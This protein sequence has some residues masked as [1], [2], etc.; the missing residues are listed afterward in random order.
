MAFLMAA[1][2]AF[3]GTALLLKAGGAFPRLT[4]GPSGSEQP[5]ILLLAVVILLLL[6]GVLLVALALKEFL[7]LRRGSHVR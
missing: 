2:V 4:G 7:H 1:A 6:S 3:L 5:G